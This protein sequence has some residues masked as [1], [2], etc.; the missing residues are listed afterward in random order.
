MLWCEKLEKAKRF[1]FLVE[2]WTTKMKDNFSHFCDKL[3]KF[4]PFCCV[5]GFSKSKSFQNPASIFGIC[6]IY[7]QDLFDQWPRF[8]CK[9][10]AISAGWIWWHISCSF[11]KVRPHDESAGTD[12]TTNPDNHLRAR[13][14]TPLLQIHLDQ[15]QTKYICSNSLWTNLVITLTKIAW[16]KLFWWYEN[17]NLLGNVFWLLK[18]V[19]W[20]GWKNWFWLLLGKRAPARAL[21]KKTYFPSFTSW[22][23]KEAFFAQMFPSFPFPV[24]IRLLSKSNTCLRYEL[25]RTTSISFPRHA[26]FRSYSTDPSRNGRFWWS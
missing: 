4:S 5:T 26:F 8:V 17:G 21:C 6:V 15:G 14:T 11:I 1:V 19:F 9:I 2:F 16:F 25:A 10:C 22:Q 24:R 7:A 12:V 13:S 23:W 18:S 20:P 3:K